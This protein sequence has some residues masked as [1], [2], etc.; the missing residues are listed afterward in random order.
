MKLNWNCVYFDEE[1]KEFLQR[2]FEPS[3]EILKRDLKVDVDFNLQLHPTI[4]ECLQKDTPNNPEDDDEIDEGKSILNTKLDDELLKW[5]NQTFEESTVIFNPLTKS[6]VA[7]LGTYHRDGCCVVGYYKYENNPEKKLERTLHIF[8]HEIGHSIGA[9]HTD[10]TLDSIMCYGYVDT[11]DYAE[12]SQKEI[13]VYL[14]NIF[15]NR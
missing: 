4:P 12:K 1:A 8:L 14:T 5:G 9:E 13:E 10:N 2:L 11:L 6:G 7:G 3:I 15:M